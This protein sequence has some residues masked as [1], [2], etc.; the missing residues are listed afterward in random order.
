MARTARKPLA[1]LPFRSR[2]ETMHVTTAPLVTILLYNI[3]VIFTTC[4]DGSRSF[5]KSTRSRNAQSFDSRIPISAIACIFAEETVGNQVTR[6]R[7]FGMKDPIRV[8]LPWCSEN[9]VLRD[10]LMRY[11]SKERGSSTSLGGF[12]MARRVN[13]IVL[14]HGKLCRRLRRGRRLP[15]PRE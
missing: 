2:E 8:T 15:Y 6:T 7:A 12:S 11:L 10:W 4:Q 9:P 3:T 1:D 5:E 14:V 13:D